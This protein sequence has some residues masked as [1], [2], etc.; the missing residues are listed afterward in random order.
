MP[1]LQDFGASSAFRF[2][3]LDNMGNDEVHGP[4]RLLMVDLAG[5]WETTIFPNDRTPGSLRGLF[6]AIHGG[7]VGPGL[8]P[9]LTRMR[10]E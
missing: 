4:S 9:Q 6:T 2:L 8:H 3:M 10:R 1:N 7:D 5:G